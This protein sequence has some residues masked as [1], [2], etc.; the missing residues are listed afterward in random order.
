MVPVN[1]ANGIAEHSKIP[2]GLP[3]FQ[4]YSPRLHAVLH[5]SRKVFGTRT[6]H[7]ESLDLGRLKQALAAVSDHD[8]GISLSSL[9]PGKVGYIPIDS[10]SLNYTIGLFLLAPGS[11]IPL[12]DHPEMCVASQLVHG[13][14]D[15][16]SYDFDLRPDNNQGV[17]VDQG[18]FLAPTTRILFPR[19]G[20]NLHSFSTQ[21]GCIILDV[22]SPPY[23]ESEGREC[24]YYIAEHVEGKRYKLVLVEAPPEFEVEE[25]P[26]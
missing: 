23:D 22:M 5:E 7:P 10:E 24:S 1:N 11:S 19:S 26:V 9:R 2:R 14:V 12:H 6:Q 20:G 18:T 13:S 15:V 21:T 8:I 16:V 17:L 4:S 25:L 3:L